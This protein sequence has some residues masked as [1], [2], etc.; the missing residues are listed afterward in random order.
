MKNW[1]SLP[2]ELKFGSPTGISIDTMQNIV[3]IHRADREWPLLGG[4]PATPIKNNTVLI[5]DKDNGKLINSWGGNLFIMPH[6][7]KVDNDNNI[8]ITDV[9]LNQVFK[10]SHEGI[11]LMKIGEAKVSGNDSLH[12]NKPTD[13]AIT[14]D[15]SFYISDG[16]G[17]SRIIKFSATGKYLF[18]WGKKGDKESEFNIPHGITLDEN[19]N[20]YVADR[21]NNRIQVF[22]K[23]GRFL[24]QITDNSFGAICAVAFDKK[25]SKLFAVDDFTFLKFRHRGSDAFILDALGNV[26]T[27]FGRSG[28]YEGKTAWYH[29][30]TIDSDGNIYIGDILENTVQKFRFKK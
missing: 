9:G 22:D 24:K 19:E 28:F 17:N 4:M 21:E 30:L 23:N 20:V 25:Q 2:E 27:R 18:E 29:T 10:F 13:I 8:W 5:I 14:K 12:F 7:L 26:E 3:L 1:L 6:G 16:Y 11:L 15:G